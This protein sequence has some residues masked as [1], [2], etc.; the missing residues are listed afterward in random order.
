MIGQNP[1]RSFKYEELQVIEEPDKIEYP[2]NEFTMRKYHNTEYI[3][4]VH[5]S[6]SKSAQAKEYAVI[7]ALERPGE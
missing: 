2:S 1:K 6:S 3:Y 7:N 4:F 5:T